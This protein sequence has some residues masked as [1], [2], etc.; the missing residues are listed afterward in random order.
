[1][2]PDEKEIKKAMAN[3]ERLAM[4]ESSEPYTE[5][6]VTLAWE[7]LNA[8]EMPRPDAVGYFK[9]SCGDRMWIYLKTEGSIIIHATFLTDGCGV[10]LACGS[11]LTELVKNKSRSEAEKLSPLE[12]INYL[13]GLPASHHHCAVLAVNALYKALSDIKINHPKPKEDKNAKR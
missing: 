11:A 5:K 12:I 10:T 2:G 7:P 6:V 9:G 8:G 4:G 1:M 13:D 3:L